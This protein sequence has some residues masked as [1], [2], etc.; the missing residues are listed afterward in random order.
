MSEVQELGTGPNKPSGD[1]IRWYLLLAGVLLVLI[2]VVGALLISK[3]I[4]ALREEKEP[5]VLS[6][7]EPPIALAPTFTSAVSQASP[8]PPTEPPST[9]PAPVMGDPAIPLFD[10]DSAGARPG[11]EWTGFFGQVF[12]AAGKPM[13]GVSLIVWQ[14]GRAA[15]PVV[16][17]DDHGYYEI[18]LA[19]EPLAGSWTIQVLTEDWQ[20]A[21]RLFTFNTDINTQTG[22]Q[23]IQVLWKQ[24]P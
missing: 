22:I 5:V 19:D 18:H 13:P 6:P 9:L 20:P 4:P 7:T 21:S 12:D 17:T 3:G 1:S 10:F 24:I 11:V 23:Q 16:Q 14:E 15:S 8:L 2:V